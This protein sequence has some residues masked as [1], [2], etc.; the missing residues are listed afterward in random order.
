MLVCD[1]TTLQVSVKLLVNDKHLSCLFCRQV[2]PSTPPLSL[3][4]VLSAGKQVQISCRFV[5]EVIFLLYVVFNDG[6][7]TQVCHY[8]LNAGKEASRDGL[9]GSQSRIKLFLFR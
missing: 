2:A 5:S 4:N 9:S 3:K 7:D 1:A 8:G 6:Q